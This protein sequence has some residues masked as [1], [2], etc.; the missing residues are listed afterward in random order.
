MPVARTALAAF[1][2]LAALG[3]TAAPPLSAQTAVTV[4]SL[5]MRSSAGTDST[6]VQGDTIVVNVYYSS[7]TDV[8]SLPARLYLGIGTATRTAQWTGPSD[9]CDCGSGGATWFR[10]RYVVQGGDF[11]ADGITT[12]SLAAW[13]ITAANGDQI[14]GSLTGVKITN[15]AAHKVDGTLGY[16]KVTGVTITSSAGS[17]STYAAGDTIAVTVA[18]DSTVAVTGTPQ[19]ALG[20]GS[21]TRQASYASGTG[22]ASLVFRY[23]VVGGDRDTDG[24][25]IGA[26]ALTLNGGTIRLGTKDAVLSLGS[27]AI[28]NAA[29]HKVDGGVVVIGVGI[30]SSAGSDSTYVQ[31]DTIKVLVVFSESVDVTGA[32]QLALGIDTLTRQASYVSGTG[33]DSL[34]FHYVLPGSST[35]RDADGLS[36]GASALTLNG[37]TI[38]RAGSGTVNATLGLGAHAISN[39]RDHQVARRPAMAPIH[40]QTNPASDQTFAAGENIELR[41]TWNTRVDKPTWQGMRLAIEIGADTVTAMPYQQNP[42]AVWFR[43]T[44]TNADLDENGISL[45]ENALTNIGSVTLEGTLVEAD[46]DL[47]A[48]TLADTATHKVNGARN[49][50]H[51]T[52]TSIASDAGTD[53]TY[54]RGDVIEIGVGF[55]ENVDVGGSP[56]LAM[57]VGTATRQAVY[58][59][60]TGGDSLAFRYVVGPGDVDADGISIGSSALTL[61]GGTIR[62]TGALVDAYLGLRVHTVAAAGA[63]KVDGAAGPPAVVGMPIA[64]DAGTDS[65]YAANDTIEVAVVFNESVDVGGTPR[66]ALGI[67]LRTR[68]ASYAGGTGTDSLTF[69]YVVAS[70]DADSDGL[71]IG[72]SALALNGG[73]IKRA[74]DATVDAALSTANFVVANAAAHKVL[75]SGATIVTGTSFA[76]DA[77]TDSI[78]VEGDTVAVEVV[79]NQA[80]DVTGTPQLALVLSAVVQ[81]SYVSGTGTATLR[82]NYVVASGDSDT[83]GIS[84]GRDAL[85][86]NGGTI[87][88]AGTAT[89]AYLSL[90]THV[91]TDDRSHRVWEVPKVSSVSI[92]TGAG[93]DQT[94]ASGE[95]IDFFTV[96]DRGIAAS[97][98]ASSAI[99][100]TIGE[101]VRAGYIHNVNTG[102]RTLHWRYVPTLADLDAD[103]LSVDSVALGGSDY[104]RTAGAPAG[105]ANAFLEFT[106]IANASAHKVNGAQAVPHATGTAIASDAGGDDTYALGDTVEVGLVFNEN[107]D[108]TG[109]PQLALGIGS[110][111]KQASYVSGTGGDS[112]TFRYVVAAGDAD[113]DGISIG[114]GALALNGGT[115]RRAGSATVNAYLGLR[116]HVVANASAHKVDGSLGPPGVAGL[117]IGSPE[118]GDTFERGETIE[119]KVVF[120][121]SVDVT[122]TPRLALGIGSATKQADYA[123]GTGTD[124]L[125]FRYVVVTADVDADGLSI[126]SGALALNGGTVRVSGGPTDALLGLGAHAVANSTG[127]KVAGGTFTASAPSGVAIASAP[128]SDSTYGRTERIEVEVSFTRP[129]DVT[130]TPQLALGIDT[131]TRQASYASGSGTNTLAF[132]YTVVAADADSTGISVG[133]S[134]LTLNSGTI[135]DARDGSTA[136]GLGLGSHAIADA[137]AH[138]V[139]GSLGP[140]TVSGVSFEY[141]PHNATYERGE[142]IGVRVQFHRAVDVT[143][144]PRLALGIGSATRQASY[145]S[146]TGT[147]TL[148]FRYTVVQSDDDGNGISIGASA[149]TLNGGTIRLSGA[150]V[151]ALLDLGSH[152]VA[153]EGFQRVDGSLFTTPYASGMAVRS[154]PASANTYQLGERI[155]VLVTFTT[156]VTVTGTPR[157]ALGIGSATRQAEYA[158]GTGTRDVWFH[159]VVAAADVDAD[160]ISIGGSALALNGGTINDARAGGSAALL[161][162]AGEAF[163][164]DGDHR[165]N[166]GIGAPSVSGLVVASPPVGDTFER[167]DVV[168]AT[169]EFNA[170]VT[171]T[172]TPQLA[173][174][175]GAV[176]RQASYAS[177]T[178][179]SSLVFRYT[180]VQADADADGLSVGASALALNGGTVRRTG[181][182]TNAVLGLGGHAVTNSAGHKVSGATLTASSP[183]GLAITSS[184]VVGDTY[185]QGDTIAVEVSFV[186]PVT[187]TGTPQLALAIGD[188]T[189]QAGYSSG[190]GTSTLEFRYVVAASDAD[191]DG[192]GIGSGALALNG[193]TIVDARDGSTAA[194]LGLGSH[195]IASASGHKV[196]GAVPYVTSAF[197]LSATNAGLSYASTDSVFG[198]GDQIRVGVGFNAGVTATGTPRLALG[199]G[200]QTRSAAQCGTTGGGVILVFCYTVVAADADST[201]ISIGASALTLPG[202]ATIRATGTTTDARLSLVPW[203]FADAVAYQVDGSKEVAPGVA[204]VA[205]SSAPA[206]DSTYGRTEAIEVEV[207]FERSVDVTGAP[208]LAL[209]IDTLTRQASYASGGGTRT[210]TFRYVVAAVDA[211]STGIS[212][213]ASA[214]TLNGGAIVLSGG[215]TAA[216]LGLGTHAITN[217]AAHKVNGS[218]GPPGVTGLAIGSPVV[219]D[220]FE[221]GETIEVELEFNRAVDVTG[222][223]RLALTIGSATRQASY[224]SG[225]GTT[226]LVFRYVVASGDADADGLSIGSGALTLSGGTIRLAGGTLDATLGLGTGVV[227]TNSG[228]HQVSG[229]TFTVPAVTAVT[230]SSAPASGQTYQ[231]GE[232]IEVKVAFGRPVAVTGAPRLAL[233][234]GT[235]TRQAGYDA[236]SSKADTLVFGYAVR[237]SDADADGLGIAASA[238]TLS[239][240]TIADVRPGAVAAALDLGS[241]A[242]TNDAS[243]KVN[244]GLGPPGVTGLTVASPPT[245]TTFER[246]DTIVATVT[247]NKAVD[248]TGTP[249]LALGIGSQT[250]QAAYAS[251]TGTASLV[252]RY[253]VATADADA[254]GLSIGANALAL[255]GGTI[256]VAGGTTDALLSLEHYAFGNASNMLVA[257]GTFTAASVSGVTIS[258][259]PAGG[260][261]YGLSE[262]IGVEVTFNRNVAVTGSPELA[263]TIGSQTRQAS[264]VTTTGGRVLSFAYTVVAA[265][266]DGNG[267]SIGASALSLNGGTIADARDANEAASLGLGSHAISNAGSHR[268]DG[269]QGPPGV[270]GVSIASPVVGD[271]FERGDTVVA[272]I[273]FNKAVDVTGTPQLA[274]T[275]GSTTKQA[276]YASGTGTASLVFRYVVVTADAD[277]DGISI[278]A[279]ALALNGGTIDVAGGTVDAVLG[280]GTHAVTNSD[281]HK[282][283]GGTFTAASVSGV[284]LTSSPAVATTYGRDESIEV[285]VTFNRRVAVTGTPQVALTVGAQT[286]Q[287]DYASGTGTRALTFR[288]VVVAA[289]ADADGIEVGASALA[290]NS[291]T[292]ADARDGSTAASLGLGSHALSAAAGH[293]VAG[294]LAGASVTGVAVSSTPDSADTYG[295]GERIEVEV[296][297]DRAV[298][299]TGAPEL[300]LT[301]GAVARQAGY[302]GGSGTAT[303]SF[304]Y[305]VRGAGSGGSGTGGVDADADG[306][307][308]AAAALTLNGGTIVNT[309]DGVRP[310]TLAL[311]AHAIAAAANDKVDGTVEVAPVVVGV[312]VTSEPVATGLYGAGGVIRVEVTFSRPVDVAGASSSPALAASMSAA[313]AANTAAARLAIDVG[314]TTR[315]ARYVSGSGTAVLAFEYVVRP[316][317]RD[318]DGISIPADALAEA[319]GA[320]RIAGGTT[321]AA[322]DLGAH[323]VTDLTGHAVNGAGSLDPVFGRLEYEFELAENVAGPLPVGEVV[324]ASPLGAEVRYGLESG[325]EGLFEVDVSSGVVTYVGG[326]ED[327]E[328]RSEYVMLVVAV[329]GGVGEDEQLETLA[330]VTVKVVNENDE[331]PSFVEERWAFEL[332]EDIAGPLALGVLE[333]VDLDEGDTLTYALVAGDRERFELD[334]QTGELR[335]VGAGEDY[336]AGAGPWVLEATATDLLGRTART[337]ATVAVADVNEPPAFADSAYAFELAENVAGPLV[338]GAVRATDPDRDDPPAY[339]LAE[340]DAERFEVDAVTGEVR[341][342][343]AGEDAET[344][345]ESWALEVRATDRGGVA[346][347]ASVTVALLDRNEAPVF[348][349]ER[350]EWEFE[351][352]VAGPLVLGMVEAADPDRADTLVYSL[353]GEA[354]ALFEVD[355]GT[356]E[357]RYAGAG[358]DYEAGPASW[359]FEVVATDGEGMAARAVATVALLDVNEAPSFADSAYAFELAENAAGPLTL[360]MV[361]ATDPDRGDAPAYSLAEGDAARFEVDA[362]TGEVRYV[363]SGEDYEQGPPTFALTVRATDAGG[364]TAEAGVSVTLL[365]VNEGPEAVG[366]MSPKTLEAYGA[367]VEEELAQ[368]FRDPDGDA[369]AYAVESSAPAVAD[370]TVTGA[371]RLSI[372]PQAIGEAVVTV[373]A[374]DPGGLSAVQQVRVTVEASR[375]E[376]ARALELTLAAFGRSLGTE[377]VDAIGGRLGLGSSGALGRSHVQLGGRSL[378]CGAPGAGSGGFGGGVPGVA[379][380]ARDQTDGSVAASADGRTD[381]DAANAVHEQA[382]AGEGH[383]E[384]GDDSGAAGIGGSGHCGLESLV[385]GATGLLGLQIAHPGSADAA[386]GTVDLAALLFGDGRG[387]AFGQPTAGG[388][389]GMGGMGGMGGAYQGRQQPEAGRADRTG[390][391][392]FNPVDARGLRSQSSF[393]LAFGGPDAPADASSA[394]ASASSQ[395]AVRSGWTVWGQANLGEFEGRPRDDFAMDGR[396]RS[397]YLGLDYRFGSGFLMGLAGSRSD[398]EAGFDSD[399][400][401]AGS[402]DARLTSLYPYLHWSSG[403]GFGVWGLAGAGRGDATLEESAGGRFDTDL[404]MRMGALGVRQEL[405]GGLALKADAFAVRILSD[406]VAGMA[407]VTADAQRVRLAPEIGGQWSLGGGLAMR[408]RLEVGGRFDGGDA[409]TGMGAEA[410]AEVG[411]AHQASGF[412]MTA[413]GRALLV[414]QERDFKDWGAGFSLRLQPGGEGE[415]GLSFS[416]EPT[417]GDAGAGART[418]W[419]GGADVW[420]TAGAGGFGA[421]GR[422][423]RPV[424][425]NVPAG[426]GLARNPGDPSAQDASAADGDAAAGSQA[427]LGLPASSGL[428]AATSAPGWAPDR[429]AMEVGYGV[430]L[431]GGNQ[432]K[433]FGRW[434]R[435]GPTGHRV[436]VGTRWSLLGGETAGQEPAAPGLRLTMDLFGEHVASGVQPPERRVG[437]SGRIVFE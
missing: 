401:G 7:N 336:E 115:V 69:R 14:N 165:V 413:R 67:G 72:A 382:D 237:P 113:S 105:A 364:L 3:T 15:A 318:P 87:R 96:F 420:R 65:T 392:T 321:L 232:S 63:H 373:R 277:A 360:G 127:H 175:I 130:G 180:V 330:K 223:P 49:V 190:S 149:L 153:N 260:G 379:S 210:L 136:A 88:R 252:F 230:V 177:G 91:A 400:N 54:A 239:G 278:G 1:G 314:G 179:T 421:P 395:A 405:T 24:I 202:G 102:T 362:G 168:A 221:R 22:S 215:T 338:L 327:A 370:A 211:D 345:P 158:R 244:G 80:V 291:G 107:V 315:H 152:A 354:A 224:A 403:G 28:A 29:A 276:S 261:T 393:Q 290:L 263:L 128:S 144:T 181:T 320:L 434:S 296:T 43:Y 335:Y 187:A 124:T 200:A 294:T 64:S 341:Y 425:A 369:L 398:M 83:N 195:A 411:L 334:G 251:G 42:W 304:A 313:T 39:D 34:A 184:P 289:D 309:A 172:G 208:Q 396:T 140:P 12:D 265:D 254:N 270:S 331:A 52:S 378:A 249:R 57:T 386:G 86:L 157:V 193:G 59:S 423:A 363:G 9:G 26:G 422:I 139:D 366:A 178:G 25:S 292:I 324:A 365:D 356:G 302:A 383:A 74:G 429:V 110:A 299:V 145:V 372:A 18:F 359:E 82:F 132:H 48:V 298:T 286:R 121:K 68:R 79:F 192:I 284:A 147:T 77:G 418:L 161:T 348:A 36:I 61:N 426:S 262:E 81:A 103:G 73:T 98:T 199:I 228:G 78:Y 154:S 55:N 95:I 142:Q 407:G 424:G 17:D 155:L 137:A 191:A 173:L 60:G 323:A 353:S 293:K 269:T 303:L 358:E 209:S 234:I 368:Y 166:G 138:K 243:H 264:Y 53:S 240:G 6:Y 409:E 2:L 40:F 305:R 33:N 430:L 271:T 226:G 100:L 399:V 206:S 247:F 111:T 384:G 212:V 337:T 268:V 8:N 267:L 171:V 126:G 377:T 70:G 76:S 340:G 58:A 122:G 281:G 135:N 114:A 150:M 99:Y 390:G 435:E 129:V 233:T 300:A 213:G 44:V 391:L 279:T 90:W 361:E 182:T 387:G 148:L 131:L 326:G 432:V 253:V 325:G 433:P 93:A 35:D 288:Y 170:A 241:S 229:S 273:V 120:N 188:S 141:D 406:D 417:W 344:G 112:L 350:Y 301:V 143:G 317:D 119:V 328:Q 410:G 227:V 123:A 297:F 219:G 231:L 204:G 242:V 62:R 248:V 19:L 66:L 30:A 282:V 32:P 245:G 385:R 412:S 272:T 198:L 156:P 388:A 197:F 16:P 255:N 23:V 38:R 108:V 285:Q 349:A 342:V 134:A 27:H 159:Y 307:G 4:D 207:E 164:N 312:A 37:G 41:I 371:G 109:T 160:G 397:A 428:L 146:G 380:A 319:A 205:I 402:V 75:G 357:V 431:P 376:R 266:A 355:A 125:V 374:S 71:S 167:G 236:A 394:G 333:A 222:T 427:S 218:L 367:A 258:S 280:L 201:G 84:Y 11:D 85:T 21:A 295:L 310:A 20:I 104:V 163:S 56:R 347:V 203:N 329:T 194:G 133:A 259:S 5:R 45:P 169:V 257:G 89:D 436:N 352:N 10:F 381:G 216:T 101:D 346:V 174:G 235:T 287:A 332:A 238:L 339:S 415:G 419:Q 416:V 117:A 186:R 414:H 316:A 116:V 375:S 250:R 283:A 437:L 151:D 13:D 185:V 162:L 106:P 31:G 46:N 196:A 389:G 311:G 189:R 176:T 343:G 408:T 118:V 404:E 351:E 97:V 92:P 50:P 274:L 94:W 308:V 217:A 214:L 246:G 322:L 183:S 225:T 47:S 220:V 51:V 256:D 306:I 275:I